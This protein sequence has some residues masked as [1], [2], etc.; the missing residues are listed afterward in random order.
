MLPSTPSR[1]RIIL[2]FLAAPTIVPWV[3]CVLVDGGIRHDSVWE[4]LCCLLFSSSYGLPIAFI[5]EFSLGL[6]V[7]LLFCHFGVR[8]FPAFLGA[9][10][11]IGWLVVSFA[12]IGVIGP[13]NLSLL[14]PISKEFPFVVVVG[15]SASAILFRAIVFSR[16]GRLKP[17]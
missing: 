13:R 14:N 7:W 5:V 3:F 4:I 1:G 12:A 11:A 17:V 8:S 9:G 10:V 2:A 16:S 15:A 6:P